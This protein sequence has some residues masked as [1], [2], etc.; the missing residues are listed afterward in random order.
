[1]ATKAESRL[2][3]RIQQ[4]I[5][6]QYPDVWLFK[7]HGGPFQPAGIPD[8]IGCLRGRMFGF[9]VKRPGHETP[10]VIQQRTIKRLRAAG[11]IACVVTS[12][13]EA[14]DILGAMNDIIYPG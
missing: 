6:L 13:R 14:L 9:E 3:R 4:Y 1:M 2:Q 12:P 7:V 11:A 5:R 8:L 10:S